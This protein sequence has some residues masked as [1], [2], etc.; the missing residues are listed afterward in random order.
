MTK[1]LFTIALTG[2]FSTTA[3][4]ADLYVRNAGTGGAYSTVSA[5][6]TA[7]S[8]GDRIII[9]PKTNGTAYVENLT[10]N[11]SL[12]FVSETIYNKYLIQGSV[13]INPAAGR[14]VTINNLSLVNNSN[15]NVTASGPTSG[16]RT[17]INIYNSSLNNISTNQV[18]TTTNVSGS[19]VQG[20]IT[21]S[22]GR[23]TANKAQDISVYSTAADT[24]IATSDVE[25]YGNAIENVL[26]NYQPN[27]NF[28]FY[29][30]F[31]AHIMV[32][33][34]KIGST[35][36]MLN[37]TVYN[38][39]PGDIAPFY[40]SLNN[41][42]TGTINIINNAASFVVGAINA[43]IQ[44]NTNNATI[45]ASYNLFTNTFATEGN[46]IQS[47]NLGSVNMNFNN[48]DY[49]ISGMNVNAGNPD[50]SY[51]D[52]DL[53]RNDAGHYG[54]SNSWSNYWPTDSGGKPQ[55]NYLLTPRT[56]SSGTL[57]I[58]GSGFSK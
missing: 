8:E 4:A 51:T 46:I 26:S 7:A 56:I 14:V 25:V 45:N 20:S 41:T 16:G 23:V 2:L 52:L 42:T 39:T 24:S 40:I 48:T 58:T 17:T 27:Y 6:I 13:T 31:C 32:N 11:K 36:E 54:G 19:K 50:V 5:A 30:N 18:N 28:K 43:C 12:T 9:Q 21:F 53:T 3:F 15:Y 44:N 1:K 57:N 37:N 47:N 33:G 29:N 22:H 49:T 34:I 10:I 55:V 38:P 35:N